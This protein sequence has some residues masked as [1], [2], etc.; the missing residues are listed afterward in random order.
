MGISP[1]SH[2]PDKIGYTLGMQVELGTGKDFLT[3]I[4]AFPNGFD[5]EKTLYSLKRLAADIGQPIIMMS[6]WREKHTIVLPKSKQIQAKVKA[7][8][9]DH[10]DYVAV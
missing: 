4:E 5:N 8:F 10:Y 1:E 3:A 2:R 9:K 7:I 6:Y